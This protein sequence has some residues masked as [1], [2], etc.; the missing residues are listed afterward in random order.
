ML[1]AE[2]VAHE[3]AEPLNRP[4]P[5]FSHNGIFFH[6]DHVSEVNQDQISSQTDQDQALL[7]VISVNFPGLE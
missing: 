7:A 2:P 1:P 4:R 3:L 6:K 5:R